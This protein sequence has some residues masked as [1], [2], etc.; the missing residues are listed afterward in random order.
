MDNPKKELCKDYKSIVC[1]FCVRNGQDGCCLSLPEYKRRNENWKKRMH[2][3]ADEIH[4]LDLQI[5]RLREQRLGIIQKLS[6]K[7][8]ERVLIYIDQ[9]KL[10]SEVEHEVQSE[11][12]C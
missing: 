8:Y 2:A 3:K 7:D 6:Q 10:K 5:Q 1:A 9:L 11:D 4:N 12:A